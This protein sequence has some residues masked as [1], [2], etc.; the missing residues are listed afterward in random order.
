MVKISLKALR[1][2]AEMTQESA[3]KAIG[4][5]VRTLQNWENYDTSPTAQQLFKIC[6]TYN[7]ELADIFLPS[8]LAKSE[9]TEQATE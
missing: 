1:V 8:M 9:N 4:I 2:N 6:N 5:T 3:A 7:C